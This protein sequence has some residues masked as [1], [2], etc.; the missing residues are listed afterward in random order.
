MLRH[1]LRLHR[2]ELALIGSA[3]LVIGI[4]GLG[5]AALADGAGL[6]RCLGDPTA[7]GCAEGL[8]RSA[9]LSNAR[10]FFST[11]LT[12][13]SV[14]AGFVLGVGLVGQEIEYGTAALAWTLFPSRR[15][16]LGKRIALALAFLAV[17]VGFGAVAA[18]VFE[19]ARHIPPILGDSVLDY[20]VRGLPVVARS[21]LAFATALL[22]G[23]AIGRTLPTLL[24]ALPA[25]V[26]IL[27]LIELGLGAWQMGEL[28]PI[29]GPGDQYVQ[30]GYR[31]R[32]G[33]ILTS[34]EAFS[35]LPGDDPAFRERFTAVSLGW[36]GARSSDFILRETVAYGAVTG[37][38]IALTVSVVDRRRPS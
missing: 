31:D 13:I 8:E 21:F 18:D 25:F 12:V 23:S 11:A 9:F 37:F 24:V 16:W 14:I 34:A 4:I 3:L 15:M 33:R 30:E 1:V 29:S 5:M 10:P 35:I 2:A 19:R 26:A 20:Q 22:V 27:L 28:Q 7:V 38:L 36:P 32:D 17:L 6:T